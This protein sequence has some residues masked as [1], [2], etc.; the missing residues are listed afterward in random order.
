M[1]HNTGRLLPHKRIDHATH[2]GQVVPGH[3]LRHFIETRVHLAACYWYML[4][5][6]SAAAPPI[7]ADAGL[8]GQ[9]QGRWVRAGRVARPPQGEAPAAAA[10]QF[11]G[12]QSIARDM[13]G[14]WRCGCCEAFFAQH[15]T[16]VW[17]A[18]RSVV[19][20]HCHAPEAANESG[21]GVCGAVRLV[22]VH[23]MPRLHQGGVAVECAERA[24]CARGAACAQ[25]QAS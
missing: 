20:P 25:K 14:G 19:P 11:C 2:G 15:H 4:H 8:E 1:P 13:V 10:R 16:A 3:Q 18:G 12:K 23:S 24:C 21:N 22:L 9:R 17:K 6:I 5:S 7:A